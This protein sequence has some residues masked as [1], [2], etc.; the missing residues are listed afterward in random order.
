MQATANVLSSPVGR[1]VS[2]NRGSAACCA[3]RLAFPGP[4][5]K[6]K[7]LGLSRLAG[8]AVRFLVC[9]RKGLRDGSRNPSRQSPAEDVTTSG[10]AQV[11]HQFFWTGYVAATNSQ[12]PGLWSRPR[13]RG[14]PP[15]PAFRVC[16]GP[17][18]R[19]RASRGH[20]LRI[21]SRQ[22]PCKDQRFQPI[23]TR[24][25]TRALIEKYPSVAISLGAAG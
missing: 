16:R 22:I 5:L 21:T 17:S 9:G 13:S 12:S 19:R 25:A 6:I 14:D 4:K 2:K 11:I 3:E 24:G 23:S 1:K 20:R 7:L 8:K 10:E 15:R 18:R